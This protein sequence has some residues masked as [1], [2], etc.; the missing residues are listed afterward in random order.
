MGATSTHKV[1][2]P[3]GWQDTGRRVPRDHKRELGV[4]TRGPGRAGAIFGRL[5]GK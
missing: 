4:Q 1:D 5:I 3:G 2:S